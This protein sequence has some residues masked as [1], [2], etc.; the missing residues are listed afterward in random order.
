M[1]ASNRLY[2][3]RRITN[4]IAVTTDL[5]VLADKLSVFG[6]TRKPK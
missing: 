3:R 4:V 6:L 5:V 1:S 2:V